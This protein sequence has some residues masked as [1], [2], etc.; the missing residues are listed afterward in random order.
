MAGETVYRLSWEHVKQSELARYCNADPVLFK[1]TVPNSQ[2]PDEHWE[3]IERVDT[4]PWS[5][6][7]TLKAWAEA[8]REFVRNVR[9]HQ[10]EHMEPEWVP[11]EGR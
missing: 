3:P 11:V 2:I 6:Y 5:Q 7:N 8:D 4:N 1:N 10:A 9:L